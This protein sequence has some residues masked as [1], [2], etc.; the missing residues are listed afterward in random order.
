MLSQDLVQDLFPI[1]LEIKS[2]KRCVIPS[3]SQKEIWCY[4]VN[5]NLKDDSFLIYVNQNT[6][7]FEK[8]YKLIKNERGV[9][10]E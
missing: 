8:I 3:Y 7:K 5:G 10:A 9:L 6:G 1:D 4:E 2:I